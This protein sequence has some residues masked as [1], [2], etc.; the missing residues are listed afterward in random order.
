MLIPS[1]VGQTHSSS[2]A[3]SQGSKAQTDNT[4][5]SQD[6]GSL[7]NAK[8]GGT[9]PQPV[10]TVRSTAAATSGSAQ[11][12]PA[13]VDAPSQAI[14]DK[15]QGDDAIAA[16]PNT[17][18]TV[19]S[20]PTAADALTSGVKPA[21]TTADDTA[22]ALDTSAAQTLMALLAQ[23]QPALAPAPSRVAGAAA[24][25]AGDQT[26]LAGVYATTGGQSRAAGAYAAATDPSLTTAADALVVT[27]A[28]TGALADQTTLL[29]TAKTQQ[30]SDKTTTGA[31][32]TATTTEKTAK[33]VVP[34]EAD[35][36]LK[37]T[38]SDDSARAAD[39]AAQ[40]LTTPALR[41]G[42]AAQ[43]TTTFSYGSGATALNKKSAVT[44]DAAMTTT[45]PVVTPTLSAA[46]NGASATPV[47][48]SALISA[49]LGSDEW[50]QAIGQ[51]VVMFSRNGQQSAELR[52][53]PENLGA[54]KISLQVD[55]NQ[56]QIHLASGH[57]SVRAA[58]EAALPHLRTALADSGITL[59]QSS[60]GSETTP[61]WGGND[62]SANS[63]TSGQRTFSLAQ[64]LT[65][66]DNVA[67]TVSASANRSL[68]GIDT[69]V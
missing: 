34:T 15:G 19:A 48:A 9:T 38:S 42:G 26:Q 10:A 58:L 56:A 14:A 63:Q 43:D 25:T 17:A 4:D 53:H 35:K 45:S 47:P 24:S 40:G 16:N 7:L 8:V 23:T 18:A 33:S 49:Q 1:N 31:L 39:A 36:H 61:N 52:L 69:F 20:L 62:G 55:N 41:D 27:P 29:S 21:T 22:P 28:V 32:L 65:A 30:N 60:V 11:A 51:Q 37:T 68:S 54:L 12:Q 64:T 6:F 13:N 44:L 2:A 46:G 59:G 5:L 67:S 50:Q 3:A 66:A 57:S